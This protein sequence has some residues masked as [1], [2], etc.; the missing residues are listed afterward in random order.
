MKMAEKSKIKQNI[1]S[2]NKQIINLKMKMKK[3]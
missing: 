1:K 3:K 2:K